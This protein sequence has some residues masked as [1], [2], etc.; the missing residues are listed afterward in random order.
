VDKDL[1]IQIHGDARTIV[2]HKDG[3]PAGPSLK[4]KKNA[5]T[6]VHHDDGLPAG[7][8]LK[9]KL[10]GLA[11]HQAADPDLLLQ[12]RFDECGLQD[13]NSSA[14]LLD[15]CNKP[16]L[17]AQ[18]TASF[19][20]FQAH[21]AADPNSAMCSESQRPYPAP[22]RG[23]TVVPRD[24]QYKKVYAEVLDRLQ[25]RFDEGD[26]KE[27]LTSAA[28]MLDGCN[29]PLYTVPLFPSCAGD[30]IDSC[31]AVVMRYSG[32]Q[33]PYPGLRCGSSLPRDS[34]FGPSTP[35]PTH[36]FGSLS[37]SDRDAEAQRH[38]AEER[39]MLRDHQ[40]LADVRASTLLREFSAPKAELDEVCYTDCDLS[41]LV[42]MDFY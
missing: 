34:R 8:S 32:Q 2:H 27:M 22:C 5:R 26:M 4:H 30:A 13:W 1:D 18:E 38:F 39:D 31:P 15:G 36:A 21:A 6:I 41:Y 20:C 9:H 3:L 10:V 23:S 33:R 12:S 11:V 24:P 19:G 16:P 25:C 42:N 7:A 35:T 40:L 37:L 28:D 17:M 14:D 29:R